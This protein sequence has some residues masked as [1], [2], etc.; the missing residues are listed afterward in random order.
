MHTP[1]PPEVSIVTAA[2]QGRSAETAESAEY[3]TQ[4]AWATPSGRPELIDEVADQFERPSGAQAY[5]SLDAGTR[6]PR[7]PQGWSAG[8]RS[9]HHWLERRAG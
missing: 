6:W 5:W 3:V 4:E 2:E 7:H 9:G 1:A 8:D